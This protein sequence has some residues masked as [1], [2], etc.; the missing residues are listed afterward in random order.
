MS[1]IIEHLTSA[2]SRRY[3]SANKTDEHYDRQLRSLIEYLK[4]PGLATND[5]K[6]YLEAIDPAIHSLSFLYLLRVQVQRLQKNTKLEVPKDMLPGGYLWNHT[7]RFL[8][9]FDTT[10]IRYA[11]HEWRQLVELVA[12]A[13]HV[14]A[15]PALAVKIIRDALIRLDTSGVFTSIHLILVKLALRSS[16]YVYALPVVNELLCHLPLD[17]GYA[18]S[19]SPMCSEHGSNTAFI[20]DISGF[21]TKLTYRD[22][23]KFYLYGAM[24]YMAVKKWDRASHCLNIA[25]SSPAANIVSKIMV[26]AYKKWILANL[27]EHGKLSSTPSLIAP[28]VTRIYQSLARPYISLA[29][30]FEKGDLPRL[31]AEANV[32]QSIWQADHNAGLVSQVLEAYDK[33]TIM[34]LGRTFSAL[35]M[36]D[37]L[38]RA[39]SCSKD[40]S[41]I[42]EFV[43]TLVMS[44]SVKATLSHPSN[45]QNTAMLHFSLGTQNNG[46][47]EEYIR[48]RLIERRSAFNAIAQAIVQTDS[49]LELSEENLHFLDKNQKWGAGTEKVVAMGHSEGVGGGDIDEDLMGDGH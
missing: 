22:H 42:E 27:L 35:K 44:N 4:Q 41:E 14:S 2:P 7:A 31:N 33:F 24:I 34:K 48:A 15:K 13:G 8:R 11:G 38:Q 3:A 37:V 49:T 21:S 12:S 39:T 6:G 16:S 47:H 30:A 43:T 36:P 45:D 25:I 23:L 19:K 20:T 32:G 10:Q 17:T 1:D 9:S 18:S 46:H 40:S 5:L 28:H 26:E 29:E